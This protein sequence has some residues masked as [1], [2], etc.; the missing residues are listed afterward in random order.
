M[1]LKIRFDSAMLEERGHVESMGDV[2]AHLH[3]AGVMQSITAKGIG[4]G[5]R[6][7]DDR[8]RRALEPIMGD[9]LRTLGYAPCNP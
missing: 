5:R 9:L 8:Q 7:L 2:K 4:E 6:S 1:V 3:H